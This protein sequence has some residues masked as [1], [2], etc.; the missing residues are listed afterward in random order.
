MRLSQKEIDELLRLR[1][2]NISIN[3]LMRLNMN[4]LETALTYVGVIEKIALGASN[5]RSTRSTNVGSSRLNNRT[6]KRLGMNRLGMNNKSR[7]RKLV[8]T[9]G[10][11]RRKRR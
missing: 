10:G 9:I 4:L 3:E 7:N 1:P 6:R 2:R 8:A 11:S 5:V